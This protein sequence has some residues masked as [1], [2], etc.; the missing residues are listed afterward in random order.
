MCDVGQLPT[1]HAGMILRYAEDIYRF[2]SEVSR[3]LRPGGRAILV[4]GNS[5]LKEVFIRNSNGVVRAAAMVGL[6][7]TR[8][9]ERQLPAQHRYLPMPRST[10]VP[11]GKRMRTE[12]VLT[13][14][15]K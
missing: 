3:V 4:V 10:D 11:L 9:I 13:F 7:L 5:C 6:R 8:K 14:R 15:L 2:L 1:R 12:T